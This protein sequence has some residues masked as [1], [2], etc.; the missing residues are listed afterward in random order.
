MISVDDRCTRHACCPAMVVSPITCDFVIVDV[1]S[2]FP[3]FEKFVLAVSV[4]AALGPAVA[5]SVR[6]KCA[7]LETIDSRS[8]PSVDFVSELKLST[9]PD[10][11]MIPLTFVP[12]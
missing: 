11:S 5:G 2:V 8:T 3:S 7:M 12:C 1:F 4:H 9:C 6:R 10:G